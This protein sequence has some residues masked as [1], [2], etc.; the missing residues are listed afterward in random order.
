MSKKKDKTVVN[1]L[2]IDGEEFTK[3]RRAFMNPNECSDMITTMIVNLMD[4]MIRRREDNWSH[5][6]RSFGFEDVYDAES[7]GFT[8]RV[9]WLNR[10][11]QQLTSNDD[12]TEE[13]QL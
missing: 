13:S 8:F 9:D 11:M 3:F 7:Q 10:T 4:E 6:A 1:E 5:V 12:T 2:P